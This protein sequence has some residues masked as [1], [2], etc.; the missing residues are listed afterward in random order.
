MAA[1]AV[2]EAYIYSYSKHDLLITVQRKL[3]SWEVIGLGLGWLRAEVRGDS[4]GYST[5]KLNWGLAGCARW[6]KVT[7]TVGIQ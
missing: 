5:L 3:L 6:R 4:Y 2:A 7:V 1:R